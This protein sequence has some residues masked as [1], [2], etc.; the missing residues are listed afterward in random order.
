MFTVRASSSHIAERVYEKKTRPAHPITTD[1]ATTSSGT[2]RRS[3]AGSVGPVL[4]KGASER[5]VTDAKPSAGTRSEPYVRHDFVRDCLQALRRREVTEPQH[6]LSTTRVDERLR[7][8][9]D[10]LRGSDEIVA[11]VLVGIASTPERA[12]LG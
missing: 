1:A 8:L 7:F 9:G 12:A 10:L 5:A 3:S 2:G 6:E 11:D 4:R